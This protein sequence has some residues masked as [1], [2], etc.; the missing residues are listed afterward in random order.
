LLVVS[1]GPVEGALATSLPIPAGSLLGP[2]AESSLSQPFAAIPAAAKN[3]TGKSIRFIIIS[4][5]DCMCESL[6]RSAS[7]MPAFK[8]FSLAGY[9]V[10]LSQKL[11]V[12]EVCC[13]AF[14]T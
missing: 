12:L 2:T 7:L 8:S 6:L 11:P 3:S 10:Y 4:F 14:A 9:H 13:P 5:L 1:L